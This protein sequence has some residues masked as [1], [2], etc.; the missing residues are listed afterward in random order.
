MHL[1]SRLGVTLLLTG[2]LAGCGN[3]PQ[4]RV[5]ELRGQVLEIRPEHSEIM[6]RHEDI[7]DFMPAMTMPFQVADDALLAEKVPGDLVTAT[8]VIEEVRAYLTTVEVTGHADLETTPELPAITFANLL[9]LGETAP[10]DSL[11]NSDG[12]T[13]SLSSL[14][15]HRVVLTFIYTRC[16]LPDFCPLMDRNFAMLQEAI[17]STPALA[18][19]QLVSVSIDPSFDTPVVLR[20]HADA[21]GADSAIWHFVTTDEIADF[22]APFGVTLTQDPTD[23]LQIVHNLRTA[24]LDPAGRLVTVR[25]GNTWTPADLIDDLQTVP[26]VVN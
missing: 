9:S 26:A 21:L 7:P 2:S 14:Q 17:R 25:N 16:P 24:V 6:I 8:L 12:D 5:Y 10:G 19:V 13:W 15:G 18:D 4:V 1:R 23:A 22:A 20:A 11:V 3:P